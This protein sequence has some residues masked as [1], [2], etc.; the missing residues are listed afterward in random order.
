MVSKTIPNTPSPL[1]EGW[2]EDSENIAIIGGGRWAKVLAEVVCGIIPTS[3]TVSIHSNHGFQSIT[4][5]IVNKGLS[6]K[7]KAFS[8]WPDFSLQ[9]SRAV[10]VVNA[11]RD[12]EKAICWA[13]DAKVPV[14]VEKP[15]A[16]SS[17]SAQGLIEKA[18]TQTT[19]LATAHIFLF[20]RYLHNFYNII[21][22][23]GDI[24]SIQFSWMD[25]SSESRY[26]EKKQYDAGLPIYSD[27]LPHILSILGILTPGSPQSC[28]KIKFLKGGSDLDINLNL[29]NIPCIVKMTRNGSRRMRI[30]KVC[31]NEKIYELDFSTEPGIIRYGTEEING[32]QDWEWKERP[33]SL[34]LNAFLQGALGIKFDKRL[35]ASIGLQ[36]CKVIDQASVLYNTQK[37]IWLTEKLLRQNTIDD[38]LR[39]A[40]TE[41][42]LSKQ[43]I[44][45]NELEGEIEKLKKKIVI[46][47]NKVLSEE[48]K[49]IT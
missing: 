42:I 27:W 38:E 23:A 11:A 19:Y 36:A 15:M 34:M 32:D 12:H 44:G 25:P 17:A 18:N 20:A 13:L 4:E 40:L 8:A 49:I 35:D 9:K 3:T 7:V 46:S 10:I 1:G 48:L 6:N 45:K 33:S 28:E 26:G 5:W 37:Y 39:Y 31:I 43:T 21:K 41:I 24:S 22:D 16:L 29:G 14:L 47:P 30:I 2:G